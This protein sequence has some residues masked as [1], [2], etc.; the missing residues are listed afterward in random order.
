MVDRA[1]TSAEQID[2][3]GASPSVHTPIRLTRALLA[4]CYGNWRSEPALKTGGLSI[5]LRL[6]LFTWIA[7]RQAARQ[8]RSSICR[9]DLQPGRCG[10]G[11]GERVHFNKLITQAAA[12][13]H[14]VIVAALFHLS[15]AGSHRP[16][17]AGSLTFANKISLNRNR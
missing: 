14:S 4:C 8:E 2:A 7:P 13:F 5:K 17:V 6:I 10:V 1:P 16:D 9:G 3:S 12:F 15:T 11:G